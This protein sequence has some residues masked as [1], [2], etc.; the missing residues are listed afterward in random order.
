MSK[1][2]KKKSQSTKLGPRNDPIGLARRSLIN[3]ELIEHLYAANKEGHVV[4]QLV[5]S[6]LAI[7][8]FPKEQNLYDRFR[9]WRLSDLEDDQWPPLIPVI[10]TEADTKTLFDILRHMR[11]ALCHG[12]VTF[13][14]HGPDGPDSRDVKSIWIEFADRDN[15]DS[16][17]D[18][19]FRIEGKDLKKFCRMMEYVVF[20]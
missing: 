4:T 18:W 15:F 3:L 11:N 9:Q 1:Q 13:Y 2:Q 6:L 10:D 16:P 7:I 17:I 19:V 20:R 5:Q 14:G 8:V 12:L